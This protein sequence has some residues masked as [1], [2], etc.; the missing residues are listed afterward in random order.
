MAAINQNGEPRKKPTMLKAADVIRLS[1][2]LDIRGKNSDWK[3][4]T[5][6]KL[7]EDISSELSLKVSVYT[8]RA[9]IKNC[10]LEQ[11]GARKKKL[12]PESLNHSSTGNRAKL[13]A[14]RHAIVDL[15]K[16]FGKDVPEALLHWNNNGAKKGD[17]ETNTQTETSKS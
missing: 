11:P 8:L 15:Y 6:D 13:W 17:N 5:H 2:W 7:I 12:S 9:M 14:L 1:R 16:E 3:Q 4:N 10:G